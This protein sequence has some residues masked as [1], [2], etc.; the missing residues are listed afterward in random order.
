[1][2]FLSFKFFSNKKV[3]NYLIISF[4]SIIVSLYLFEGYLNLN[5]DNRKKILKKKEYLYKKETGKK[6]DTRN[7]IDIYYDKKKKNK[8]IQIAFSVTY[9]IKE[10]KNFNTDRY[11]LFPLSGISNSETIH[12]N[13]NGYYSVY[14]SDRFGFNNPNNEWEKKEI[15]YLLVG[16]SFILGACVNRPNDIASILRTQSNKAVLNL[17]YDGHGPL[18]QYAIL[19]E[20]LKEKKVKKILWFFTEANDLSDLHGELKLPALTKY[21]NDLEFNQ[22]LKM[23]QNEIN[24]LLL[25]M[26]QQFIK[27]HTKFEKKYLNQ[28]NKNKKIK[29][30]I[31]KYIRLDQTKNV[32]FNIKKEEENLDEKEIYNTLKKILKLADNL[33]TKN[34]SELYLVYL[35]EYKRYKTLF[36]DSRYSKVKTIAN[37]L[38]IFFVDI[39][40]VF[41]KNKN[42]MNFFPFGLVGHYNKQGYKKIGETIYKLNDT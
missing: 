3:K 27:D 16:D 40:A 28:K 39:N 20:Y 30:K 5:K 14:E 36:T 2:K 35:P 32:I 19:R 25:N 29:N 21:I 4:L 15:E 9:L 33:A 22:N 17:G 34:N 1:M 38:N 6:Y 37:D 11:E 7:R 42:P 8:N 18:G 24:K 41:N 12:C 31:L 10:S 13:E 26:K 23:K